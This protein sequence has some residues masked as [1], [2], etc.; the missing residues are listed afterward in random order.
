MDSL[1]CGPSFVR[2]LIFF[3]DPKSLVRVYSLLSLIAVVKFLGD[4]A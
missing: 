4:S 1:Q 2:C 3:S